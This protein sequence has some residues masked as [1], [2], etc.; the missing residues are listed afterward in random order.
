MPETARPE[1]HYAA[2]DSDGPRRASGPGARP[3]DRADDYLCKPFELAELLARIRA[4]IRRD[5]IHRGQI[6]RID[7]LEI[8][9]GSQRVRCAGREV[10]LAPQEYSLLEALAR[11]EGRVVTR[12]FIL[13]RVWHNEDSYSN[14][15]DVHITFLRKKIDTGYDHRLIQ[16]VHRQGYMLKAPEGDSP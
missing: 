10:S 3:G 13:N 12:D 14:S 1:E 6:I 5:K 4:L 8:D 7:R 16:T 15:V 2:P 11:Q 9:T